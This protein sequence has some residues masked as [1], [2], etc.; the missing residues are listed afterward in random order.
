MHVYDKIIDV[1]FMKYTQY[2][3][4]F[5]NFLEKKV[6]IKIIYLNKIHTIY[7]FIVIM[8]FGKQSS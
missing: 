6:N 1:Y 4:L 7:R 3:I 2:I 5:F 8:L